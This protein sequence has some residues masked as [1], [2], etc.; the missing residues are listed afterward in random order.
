[1]RTRIAAALALI[2]LSAPALIAG[3]ALMRPCATE[4]S[5]LCSWDASAH[6][7]TGRDFTAITD[8]LIIYWN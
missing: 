3:S 1:M 8:N 4:D 5:T 2:L 6:G 7:S